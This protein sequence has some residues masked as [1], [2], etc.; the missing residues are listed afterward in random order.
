MKIKPDDRVRITE[1]Q[2]DYVSAASINLLIATKGS[3][4]RVISLD[5]FINHYLEVLALNN[6]STGWKKF[7]DEIIDKNLAFFREVIKTESMYPLEVESVEAHEPFQPEDCDFD[8]YVG[9]IILL[10]SRY[11]EVIK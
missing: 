11:I 9:K 3:F 7:D 5:E 1:N 2:Y 6:R 8:C 10:E 4:A